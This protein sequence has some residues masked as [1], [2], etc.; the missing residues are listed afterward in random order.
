MYKFI[1][2]ASAGVF[3]FLTAG[4]A[5]AHP[6]PSFNCQTARN[7]TEITIC[8]SRKLS[9]LDRRMSYWYHRAKER[10]RYFDQTRWLR[11]QQRHWLRARNRCGWNRH[12]IAHKYRNRIRVLRNYFEHV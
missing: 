7:A 11:H 3:L 9:R 2:S 1:L 10:A 6:G 5:Q 8:E 12:C 4:V